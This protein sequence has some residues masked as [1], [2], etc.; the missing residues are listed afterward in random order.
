MNISTSLFGVG[1]AMG[2]C[3]WKASPE[4]KI[5]HWIYWASLLNAIKSLKNKCRYY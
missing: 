1:M 2:L 4:I 3:Y 5:I